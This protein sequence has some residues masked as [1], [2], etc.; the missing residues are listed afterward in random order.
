ME[1]QYN[2]YFEIEPMDENPEDFE[3]TEQTPRQRFFIWLTRIIGT[4]A[5]IGLVYL[6]GLYQSSFFQRTPTDVFFETQESKGVYEK[7]SLPLTFF[8]L[9]NDSVLGSERSTDDI[10]QLVR[11]GNAILN[12]AGIDLGVRHIYTLELTDEEAALVFTNPSA[13]INSIP[14]FSRD[15]L[16]VFLVASLRGINGVA[17]RGLQSMAIADT[18]AVQDFR[19]FAHEIG[20]L[21]GLS[22]VSGDKN[23][24]MYSGANGTDLSLDEIERAREVARGLVE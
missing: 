14:Q 21:L 5:I 19:V 22:H 1:D 12:Q 9:K 10:D 7:I 18:T 15:S 2:P 8:I 23:S 17:F 6:S 11:N 4:I 24:L 3:P 20:H 16:N 13:F